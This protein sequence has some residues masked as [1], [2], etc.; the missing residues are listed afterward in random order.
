MQDIGLRND[1]GGN[2]DVA[3]VAGKRF[4]RRVTALV[5]K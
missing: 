4:F 5:P 2:V 1:V 3:V